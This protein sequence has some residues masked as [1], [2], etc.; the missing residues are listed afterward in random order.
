MRHGAALDPAPAGKPA[1]FSCCSTPS[2]VWRTAQARSRH[3]LR[4]CLAPSRLCWHPR[5][6]AAIAFGARFADGQ[7]PFEH[8]PWRASAKSLLRRD[9]RAVAR[10]L[11]T[12][13]RASPP[14]RFGGAT[15]LRSG[16]AP[17]NSTAPPPG[18]CPG[19]GA[20]PPK[21]I[22]RND[23]ASR[24]HC[25]ALDYLRYPQGPLLPK[26]LVIF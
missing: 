17:P 12:G 7:P 6:P 3:C 18:R 24:R 4:Q 15:A 13:V 2:A 11:G 22:Q 16:L 21:I 1:V 23:S 14:S 20:L 8:S 5:W 9:Q 19:P 26:I 25:I 10:P